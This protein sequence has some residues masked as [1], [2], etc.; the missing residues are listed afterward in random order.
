MSLS[1]MCE[2]FGYTRQGHWRHLKEHYREEIDATALLGEV[3][4]IRK[5]MPRCGVRK[6][7]VLLEDRGHRIGRDRLFALLRSSGMLVHRKHYRVVTTYSKHWM[8]KYAN[9]VKTIIL[10]RPN[11]IW[12]S[13]ITY[14][15]VTESG[16]RYFLYLSLVTDA[17]TH[18]IVGYALHDTLDT[19]GPLKALRMALTEYGRDGLKGLIHHS[20]RGCQYCSQEYVNELKSYG[21]RISMTDHGDPYENAVAE[22]VNGILKTEWLYHIKLTSRRMANET[23]RH[24][25]QVYNNGRP[26]LSIDMRTPSQARSEVGPLNKRWKNYWALKYNTRQQP[27]SEE[28]QPEPTAAGCV[29]AAAL[30]C[31][32]AAVPVP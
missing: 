19:D 1:K 11:Q 5:E 2:L 7:Q 31:R 27:T 26:H 8:K 9:L 21:V 23:I 25:I 22:R 3:R 32:A 24:I 28:G 15:E 29:V 20:D 6:I 17:Y 10:D 16:K 18:E 14:V 30:P 12:V 13:D 4:E